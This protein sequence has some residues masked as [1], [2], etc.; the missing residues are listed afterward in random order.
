V[1]A[2]TTPSAHLR[3]ALEL[4][5]PAMADVGRRFWHHTELARLYPRYLVAVHT[6]IRASVP[7]MVE[8]RRVTEESYVDTPAGPMLAAYLAKHIPEETS[9]D[10]WLLDDLER[11][12]LPRSVALTHVPSP[13]VAAM[14]GAQY[15]YIH[16]VHP[17]VLLGYIAVLEGYPPAEELATTAAERTGLPL[18][19]FRT[20]RKHANLDPHHR[21]DLDDMYD[22]LPLE[23]ELRAVVRANAMRTAD[24]L[25]QL[26][27]E[28]L[29]D[30]VS[31]RI[32]WKPV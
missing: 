20:L 3:G 22:A 8:A 29:D 15:Y 7:L 25:V 2:V 31:S 10:D 28:I 16:H 9:H 18:E 14:V 4:L 17:A 21:R 24:H 19:A 23:P 1:T 26:V 30:A 11:L 32:A 12:G 13:T 6:V 5:L 27:A